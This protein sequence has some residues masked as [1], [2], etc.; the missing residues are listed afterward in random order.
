MKPTVSRIRAVPL[1]APRLAWSSS[2]S[3]AAV[4][5]GGSQISSQA[6]IRPAIGVIPT[7]PRYWPIAS[8]NEDSS[9]VIAPML[10]GSDC[11]VNTELLVL[12]LRA[13]GRLATTIGTCATPDAGSRV[14]TGITRPACSG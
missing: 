8:T 9:S 7:E 4:C 5:S 10:V 14:I 2:A 11:S 3:S 13:G 6:H 1:I 12:G